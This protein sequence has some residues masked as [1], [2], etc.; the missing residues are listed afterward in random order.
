MEHRQQ[1]WALKRTHLFPDLGKASL[2]GIERK[3]DTNDDEL[4]HNLELRSGRVM[5][6][7]AWPRSGSPATGRALSRAWNSQFS[8]H[9]S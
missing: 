2:G 9:C 8:A 5:S 4:N 6:M 7:Y 1:M 3:R